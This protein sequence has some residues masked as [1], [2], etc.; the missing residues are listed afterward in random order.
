[1]V[2]CARSPPSLRR[3][4]SGEFPSLTGT[5]RRLRLPVAHPRALVASRTCTAVTPIFAPAAGSALASWRA[6]RFV[7]PVPRPVVSAPRRR[8]GLPGSWGIPTLQR[9][10]LRPRWDL[11]ALPMRRSGSADGLLHASG[12][13][14]DSLS[15]LN[16]TALQL[17]VYASWCGLPRPTQDSLPAGGQPLPGR[18]G[19]LLDPNRRFR[20]S[21]TSSFLPLQAL[22]GAQSMQNAGQLSRPPRAAAP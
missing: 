6:W 2:P 14:D 12:S 9:P 10:A 18:V 21:A 15:R 17:A 8:Q 22:P 11:G 20:D 5:M 4:L 19:Y 3:V 13:H 7:H 1:M 16:H